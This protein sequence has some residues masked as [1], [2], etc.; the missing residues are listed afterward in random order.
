MPH[1][2]QPP[3][4]LV[5]IVDPSY[6]PTRADMEE[7]FDVPQMTLEEAARRVL[8]PVAVWTIDRP[9]RDD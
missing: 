9:R 3:L 5:E 6:Q 7:P 4:R 2:K 1:P 8:E